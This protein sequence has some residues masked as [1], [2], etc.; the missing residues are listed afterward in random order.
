LHFCLGDDKF[1]LSTT[2]REDKPAVY[3]VNKQ[4]P[5]FSVPSN[6]SLIP[7]SFAPVPTKFLALSSA[8]GTYAG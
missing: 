3:S 4:F 7:V 1:L 5:L 2:S 6:S 8:N